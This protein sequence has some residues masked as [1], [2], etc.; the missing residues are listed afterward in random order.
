MSEPSLLCLDCHGLGTCL[1]GP[2]EIAQ[3]IQEKS[4][5]LHKLRVAYKTIPARSSKSDTKKSKKQVRVCEEQL[6]ALQVHQGRQGEGGTDVPCLTPECHGRISSC[7]I[8]QRRIAALHLHKHHLPNLVMIVGYLFWQ[9]HNGNTEEDEYCLVYSG[10]KT[11]EGDFLPDMLVGGEAIVRFSPLDGAQGENDADD[12]ARCY[13]R[14]T[15]QPDNVIT[16]Y[17]F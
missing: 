6:T 15:I 2:Q 17:E 1:P 7:R 3:A 5:E 13:T 9:N 10:G 8:A 14:G 16:G 4:E 12:E 11:Y